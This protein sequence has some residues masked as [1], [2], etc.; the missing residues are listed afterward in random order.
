MFR[1]QR[2]H[3][4]MYGRRGWQVW[5]VHLAD[6]TVLSCARRSVMDIQIVQD[7]TRVVVVVVDFIILLGE[8]QQAVPF[9]REP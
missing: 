5:V 1:T 6:G 8:S 3:A 4:G 9:Y 7:I 2:L